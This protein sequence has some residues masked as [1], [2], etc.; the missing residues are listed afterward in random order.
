MLENMVDTEGLMN[1]VREDIK[2]VSGLI[3]TESSPRPI[4]SISHD[5]LHRTTQGLLINEFC[6]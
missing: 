6:V 3:F 2:A 4:Q 1:Q 5:V